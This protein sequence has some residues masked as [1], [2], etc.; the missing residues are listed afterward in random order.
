[1][2][3]VNY[4]KVVLAGISGTLAVT[5]LLLI[6]PLM[7]M[8][9]MDMGQMLGPMNPMVKLPHWVGRMMQFMIMGQLLQNSASVPLD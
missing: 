9:R 8:P 2:I 4:R 3:N 1:M 7:G 5:M 6:G